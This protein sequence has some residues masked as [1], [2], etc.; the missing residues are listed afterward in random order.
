MA[1]GRPRSFDTDTALAAAMGV[2][3]RRGYEG[4]SLAELTK[5]MG[6]NPPSLY[7][8][9]GNK[10]QLFRAALDRYGERRSEFFAWVLEA[11]TAREV[12]ERIFRGTAESSTTPGEPRGC[13]VVQSG[14]ACS[15]AD[16]SVAKEIVARRRGIEEAVTARF[17]R[18]KDEGDLAPDVCPVALARYVS[19]VVQGIAL[20][21]AN[22]AE[23]E[24]LQQ[25]AEI[26][27]RT[28]PA[29]QSASDSRSAQEPAMTAGCIEPANQ[30]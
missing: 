4:A 18:A 28:L 2:F 16:D 19:A 17:Q 22:G 23:R 1:L 24:E 10:E 30:H 15:T 27:I 21:A 7:A 25:V 8:A 9:F 6:I 5:A 3:W 12:L 29:G 11:P 13:L 26:A 20:L 14:T